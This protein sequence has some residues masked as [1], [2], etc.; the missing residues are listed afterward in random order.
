MSIIAIILINIALAG[1]LSAI[2]AALMLAPT[3]LRRH[4]AEGFT[5][6][7]KAAL[8]AQ[9]QGWRHRS[10]LATAPPGASPPGA[11]FKTPSPYSDSPASV[12]RSVLIQVGR[13]G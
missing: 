11:R 9:H 7:Q 6:R 5:H 12:F 10:S 13:N 8:H 4:F 3:R 1:T 2:L